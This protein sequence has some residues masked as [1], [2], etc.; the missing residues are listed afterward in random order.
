MTF[1][2]FTLLV[3]GLA[4]LTFMFNL[5]TEKDEPDV[6]EPTATEQKP[7]QTGVL[8][9]TLNAAEDAADSLGR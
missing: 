4:A 3:A 2:K 6:E 1:A 5:F 7:G 8:R 9:N